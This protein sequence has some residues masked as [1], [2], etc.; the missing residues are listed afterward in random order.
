MKK[1]YLTLALAMAFTWV[2]AQNYQAGPTLK[3]SNSQQIAMKKAVANYHKESK[4]VNSRW[5]SYAFTIDNQNGNLGSLSFG[6]LFPDTNAL[7]EYGT[8][9]N[10][11]WIH[12]IATV[13]DPKSSWFEEPGK[14]LIT[15]TTPYTVDSIDILCS[16]YRNTS[17]TVVDTLRF[18]V[19]TSADTNATSKYYF[20]GMS[21][22]YGTDTLRFQGLKRTGLELD[23]TTKTIIDVYLNEADT[24]K[25]AMGW[26]Q[27][28]IAPN[29]SVS[30]DEVLAVT[31]KF[32]PGYTY[33]A[34]D[35]I[36]AAKNYLIF[37][38]M[39]ENGDNTYPSYTAGDWNT[40]QVIPSFATDTAS[41][42]NTIYVPEWA[43]VQ[44]YSFENHLISYKITANTGFTGIEST[45]NNGL[46]VSQNQPNPFSGIT[47]VNYSLDN[48]A[49]VS[50]AVYNV[51][52]AK[53]MSINEGM[54]TAGNHSLHI[55]ASNLQAG[56][57]YYT[58]TADGYSV[59]KKM[60]IY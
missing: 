45:S 47:T 53:V 41:G 36:T 8:S 34:T 44:A 29:T 42:W 20:T 19:T 23:G 56:V 26:N 33:S 51:A 9:T 43:F 46:S 24:A 7:F 27:F 25:D 14:Q 17:S 48:A 49:N 32:I 1:I 38:S 16:Y 4:A 18:E 22:N 59:T 2:S 11:A 39:E 15:D 60:I 35:T 58:F 37:A 30:A 6:Y 10:S 54:K 5:Y 31:V 21:N 12:S 28:T 52:G 3:I 57:Y 55:N 50:V 13:I 40:S